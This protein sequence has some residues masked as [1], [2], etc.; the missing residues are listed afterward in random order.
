MLSPD[1]QWQWDGADWT[2]AEHKP[3]KKKRV[4]LIAGAL[5]V[6]V[7]IVIALAAL[8]SNQSHDDQLNQENDQLSHCMDLRAAGTARSQL[9]DYCLQ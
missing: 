8:S 2:P 4:A 6:L 7:V 9:P 5:A 3:A 1:G